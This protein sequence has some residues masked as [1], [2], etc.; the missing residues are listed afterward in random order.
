MAAKKAE[1]LINTIE[2]KSEYPFTGCITLHIVEN[3]LYSFWEISIDSLQTNSHL[4]FIVYSIIPSTE[5]S[6]SVCKKK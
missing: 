3:N 1:K 6:N 2:F 4:C 5:L